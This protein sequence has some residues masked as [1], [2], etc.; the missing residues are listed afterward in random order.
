M[1]SD[2]QSDRDMGNSWRN[3]ALV[4]AAFAAAMTVYFTGIPEA[5]AVPSFARKYKTSCTTCHTVYPVLNPFGEAFRRDGYRFPSQDGS[6]DSDSIKDEQLALGQQEYRKMFPDAVWP[7][8]IQQAIPL[9]MMVNGGVSYNF[10]SS[11]AHDTNGNALSLNGITTEAHIFGAGAFSDSL[12]Y[13]SQLTINSGGVDI[14]TGYLLMNDVIGPRHLVN[15]WV[16][17]LMNP[18]LTSFGLHSSY[19]G[20]TYMPST[21]IAQL[22]NPSG[23]F[24]LGSG[25][26]DGVEVNGVVAHRLT[27]ALGYVGSG[28]VTG[29]KLPTSEDAYAHL[30]VKIG[31]MSFDGEGTSGT[32]VADSKRPWAE[33]SLTLDAFAYHGLSRLDSGTGV[34]PTQIVAQDDAVNA[35]GG[36]ARLYLGSFVLAS[37]VVLEH[38]NKPYQGTAATPLAGANPAAPGTPDM[39]AGTAL[40]Q[41]NEL[42]YVIYPWL[43]P[44]VRA[45]F[46][47]I[48]TRAA[49]D[50]GDSANLIRLTPGVAFLLRPNVKLVTTGTFERAT[51]MPPAQ[52]GTPPSQSWSGA[53]GFIVAPPGAVSKLEAEQINVNLAWA[54]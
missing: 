22:Y 13:F 39:T 51:G 29:L 17:R 15:V 9:S 19:L 45:E 2:L 12:T 21:S 14:E 35:L 40:S 24:A 31:G 20:D 18:S 54:F 41:Y 3:V 46:T 7:D 26:T 25:H 6:M 23:T 28:A 50:G 8:S 1:G 42:D 11:D 49:V 4:L 10:P 43:V 53:G 52:T 32:Q 27:Y 34:D 30:G 33:T 5:S 48:T 38:H 47:R 16:G 44:G 36:T 37:G